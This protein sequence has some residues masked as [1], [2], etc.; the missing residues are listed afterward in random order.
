[1]VAGCPAGSAAS[2]AVAARFF[3]SIPGRLL[4]AAWV[5]AFFYHLLNGVRHLFWDAGLG[6]ERR[7]RHLSGW[8]VVAGAALLGG[9]TLLLFAIR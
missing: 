5:F 2:Y 3:A 6:F 1:M 7:A 8:L 9:V 4:V